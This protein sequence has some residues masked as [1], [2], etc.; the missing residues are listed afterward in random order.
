MTRL[1]RVS[2]TFQDEA[3]AVL[4]TRFPISWP[5]D[6]S[7]EVVKGVLNRLLVQARSVVRSVR[8]HMRLHISSE[9]VFWYNDDAAKCRLKQACV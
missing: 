2:R 8:L 6:I 5:V 4:Y 3:E 1:V 9:R 7:K